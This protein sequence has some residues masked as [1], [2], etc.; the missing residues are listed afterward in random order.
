MY[1]HALKGALTQSDLVILGLLFLGS[2][3]LYYISRILLLRVIKPFFLKTTTPLDDIFFQTKVVHRL[4]I[5]MPLLF[6]L[7]GFQSLLDRDFAYL[8]EFERLTVSVIIVVVTAILS[9]AIN[10]LV[11]LSQYHPSTKDKPFKSIAQAIQ[12]VLYIICIV[13]VLS[14][15]LNRS[16][17]VF[18]SGVGAMTAVLLLIFKDSILGLVAGVQLSALDMVRVGDWIEVPSHNV[19]GDVMDITLNTVKVRNFDKTITMIPPYILISHAFKNYRGMMDTGARRIKRSLF[20]DQHSVRFA[21]KDDMAKWK[22]IHILQEYVLRKEQE[23]LAFN[24]E[25]ASST[26]HVVNARNITNIGTFRRYIQAYLEHHPFIEQNLT[27]LVRQLQPTPEGIPIE[28][29]AFSND[30]RWIEYERIQSDIF[31]HL[32]A[33]IGEFDLNLFQNP[34]GSDFRSMK[35]GLFS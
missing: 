10:A 8:L 21:T 27:L 15:L 5:L 33:S 13:L 12:L 7:V 17:W 1:I 28:I 9:A 25:H 31:D 30:P 19:D 6:F 16:P 14:T 18:L 34:S 2:V 26:K 3:A 32:L 35:K 24:A 4:S 11:H 22:N 20:I 29:Y 23:I